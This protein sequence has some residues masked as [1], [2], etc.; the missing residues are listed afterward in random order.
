[1]VI[2]TPGP[3]A[4]AGTLNAGIGAFFV[5]GAIIALVA[6]V[7]SGVFYAKYLG[8][9]AKNA[10]PYTETEEEATAAAATA[11]SDKK[12]SGGLGIFLIFFPIILILIGTL[13]KQFVSSETFIYQLFAFVGDK[14]IALMVGAIVA[15]FALKPYLKEK[16][17]AVIT[18]SA[19]QSG[20]IF[21]ITGAGGAFGT[22]INATGIGDK[23]VENM[24]GLT[25]TSASL[26]LIIVA[27]I[28]SQVLRA[29][30]GSTTVALVTT[31]AI[32][33]PLVAG[34]ATVSPVLVGLAI[35][36]GGIGVSLPNDSGF[37]VVNRFAKFSL[38]QTF[39]TWTIG[40]TI[41]GVTSLILI[42]ILALLQNVLPGLL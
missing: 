7:V 42:L 20:I 18:E 29:A 22:I 26:L 37:W 17:D 19:S 36:A 31:S 16:F 12:P 27:W 14:N 33:A 24:S 25:A 13:G 10:A 40:G 5:Y 23:L 28:I 6:V 21:M 39:Q 11:S 2:P 4:V 30:Q 35:C 34:M 41:A 8:R 3:L 1:M 15:F 9:M 32:L 38:K